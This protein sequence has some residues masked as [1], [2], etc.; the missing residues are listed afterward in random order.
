MYPCRKKTTLISIQRERIKV[1]WIKRAPATERPSVESQQKDKAS[2]QNTEPHQGGEASHQIKGDIEA[3]RGIEGTPDHLT[4]VEAAQVTEG[5][6][7]HPTDAGRRIIEEAQQ[8]IQEVHYKMSCVPHIVC[9][10]CA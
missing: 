2:P 7:D 8:E 6:P 4:D 3:V 9:G 10:K 1:W 5:I